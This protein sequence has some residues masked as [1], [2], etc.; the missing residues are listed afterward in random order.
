MIGTAVHL[1]FTPPSAATL[2]SFTTLSLPLA[3]FCYQSSFTRT[4]SKAE[5]FLLVVIAKVI[6]ST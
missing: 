3:T 2:Y 6:I 1:A 5:R 4:S